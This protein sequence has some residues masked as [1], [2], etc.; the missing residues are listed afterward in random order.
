MGSG[1]WALNDLKNVTNLGMTKVARTSTTTTA[2]HGDDGRVDHGTGDLSSGLDVAI[3]VVRQ[4][5]EDDV[6]VSGQLGRA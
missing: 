5:V 4:L 2:M 3:D 1:S 6:E